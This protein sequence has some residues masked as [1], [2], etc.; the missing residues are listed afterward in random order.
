M[1]GRGK[2][3]VSQRLPGGSHV[4]CALYIGR[5]QDQRDNELGLS[6]TEL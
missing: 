5:K 4:L 3:L 6:L 1:A 2:P